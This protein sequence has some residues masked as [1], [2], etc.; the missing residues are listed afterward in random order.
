MESKTLS[1]DKKTN[2]NAFFEQM[3]KEVLELIDPQTQTPYPHLTE[4]VCCPVCG[5]AGEYFLTKWHFTYEKCPHC[6][7]IFVNPRLKES[8]TLEAYESKSKANRMWASK[9]NTSAHQVKFYQ[10]YFAEQLDLLQAHIQT[11][12]LLDVGCGNGQFLSYAKENGFTVK[13]VELEQNA[14]AITREKGIAAEPLLLTDEEL[15]SQRFDAIT[16]FG[17]LEHLTNPARDLA[18]VHDMLSPEG[19][20]MGITP[21]A[22]SLVGMLLHGKARFYTPRNHPQIFSFDAIRHLFKTTGFTILHLDT[23]L[24]GYDSIV[25]TL[26]YRAPFS[27]L[28][29]D[30]LPPTVFELIKDKEKCEKLILDWG[31]GLRLRIVAQKNRSISMASPMGK[32][33]S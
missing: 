3:E 33:E 13:G 8:Q 6:K 20:F 16:M 7:L 29:L 19:I 11:G 32:I 10:T 4:Q 27:E 21:N 15:R 5:H 9:V 28:A 26:Q 17:V 31:L 25:N 22:Q 12:T 1:F 30:F 24:T 23:V 18:I 2:R 14:L